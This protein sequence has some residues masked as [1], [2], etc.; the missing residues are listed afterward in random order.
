MYGFHKVPHLQQGALHPE[1]H[2]ENWE[3]SN[4]YFRR[5]QPDLLCYVSRKKGRESDEKDGIDFGYLIQELAAI[6][7]HQLTISSDLKTMQN[8]NH[9]LWQETMAIRQ[10]NQAQQEMINKILKFLASVFQSKQRVE[11][12]SPKK[13]RL[14]L[15]DVPSHNQDNFSIHPEEEIHS[16][17][18]I[19]ANLAQGNFVIYFFPPSI[20]RIHCYIIDF[21]SA[22]LISY[23]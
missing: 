20:S 15:G 17:S 10:K 8:E 13:R 18:D 9:A 14:L 22:K 2:I 21:H 16:Q 12:P 11:G 5:G 19:F 7:R 23:F 4:P 1:T 3:F 6:K